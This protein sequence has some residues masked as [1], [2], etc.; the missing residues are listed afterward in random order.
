MTPEQKARQ[1]AEEKADNAA[2]NVVIGL[3][4]QTFTSIQESQAWLKRRIAKAILQF[5]QEQ[6]SEA[7]PVS[8]VDSL[9]AAIEGDYSKMSHADLVLTCNMLHRGRAI[10]QKEA[11]E[12]KERLNY[13]GCLF[14]GPGRGDC[15]H[16]IGLPGE[17]IDGHHDDTYGKPNGWCWYCWWSYRTAKAESAKDEAVRELVEGLKPFA[18]YAKKIPL[19]LGDGVS[20][21]H[22]W[23]E[24][25]TFGHFRKAAALIAKHSRKGVE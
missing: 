20:Y 19:A 21:A 25:L 5:A 17:L 13:H 8:K 15:E 23:P 16:F 18:V 7:V 2:E 6:E 12:L 3:M 1:V 10:W 14:A 9:V 4:G 11:E 24:G 22:T